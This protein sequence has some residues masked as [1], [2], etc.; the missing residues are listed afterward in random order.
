MLSGQLHNYY[1][2]CIS[3]TDNHLG[4]DPK[5]SPLESYMYEG[6]SS[7]TER[8]WHDYLTTQ[9]LRGRPKSFHQIDQLDCA[10]TEVCDFHW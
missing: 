4:G 1:K 7:G 3:K 8:I 6:L 10:K 2:S 9:K 5:Q